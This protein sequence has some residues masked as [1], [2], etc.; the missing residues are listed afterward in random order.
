M[1]VQRSKQAER[2]KYENV[3]ELDRRIKHI[4]EKIMEE[5][6]KFISQCDE[7][8]QLEIYKVHEE[9]MRG[10]REKWEEIFEK[11]ERK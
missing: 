9:E 11:F 3:V 7:E 5:E 10:F 4:K 6:Q 1:L 8:E 2:K